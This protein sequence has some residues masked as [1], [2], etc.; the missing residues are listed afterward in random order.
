MF[1]GLMGGVAGYQAY[2]LTGAPPRRVRIAHLVMCLGMVMMF[3]PVGWTVPR[4]AGVA[5]Y[6]AAAGMCLPARGSGGHRLHAVTGSLAMAYMFAI[7][8]M[9][10]SGMGGMGGM[11]MGPG[12]AYAWIGLALAGY[13]IVETVWGLRAL[14][15]A[16]RP[17]A[18]EAAC[19]T[20]V[21]LAMAYM[22]LTLG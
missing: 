15:A 7:P 20:T 22:L 14:L 3:A 18:V 4:A 8:G 13:F 5:G 2:R 12:G 9:P 6:L 16:D 17:S 10:M 19:H 1:A 21:G 11:A